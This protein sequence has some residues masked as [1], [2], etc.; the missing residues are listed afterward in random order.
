MTKIGDWESP[1]NEAREV[2]T[3]IWNLGMACVIS[4]RYNDTVKC[5]VLCKI[6]SSSCL[7]SCYKL[8]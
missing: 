4:R 3:S 2:K 8:A 1:Q 7:R 5:E 6:I